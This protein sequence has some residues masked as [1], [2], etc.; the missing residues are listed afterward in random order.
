MH[1]IVKMV[2]IRAI[3]KHRNAINVQM[4]LLLIIMIFA[5]SVNN[6]L[7]IVISVIRIRIACNVLQNFM[8]MPIKMVVCQSLHVK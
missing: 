8:L 1:L 4:A 5:N 3:N 6:L 2:A 7:P